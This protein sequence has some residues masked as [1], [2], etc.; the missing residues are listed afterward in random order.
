MAEEGLD[1]R[2]RWVGSSNDGLYDGESREGQEHF[3]FPPGNAIDLSFDLLHG[4]ISRS[5]ARE[6][7]CEDSGRALKRAA[8]RREG[9]FRSVPLGR[10]KAQATAKRGADGTPAVVAAPRRL[11]SRKN[12]RFPPPSA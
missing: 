11:G 6:G 3:S 12:G 10:Q 2:P 4:G 1:G 5:R 9:D 8:Q 7:N